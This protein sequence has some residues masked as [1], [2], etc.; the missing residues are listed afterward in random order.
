MF[1]NVPFQWK[2]TTEG[3][4][5]RKQITDLRCPKNVVWTLKWKK[6]GQKF[7]KGVL[8]LKKRLTPKI[9]NERIDSF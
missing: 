6:I 4:V 3:Q 1:K 5:L 8:S 9:F 7:Q 2:T